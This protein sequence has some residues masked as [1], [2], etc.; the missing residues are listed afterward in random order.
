MG[1]RKQDPYQFYYLDKVEKGLCYW[2]MD[3]RTIDFCNSFM[4]VS[5]YL[6]LFFNVKIIMKFIVIISY[7]V[8]IFLKICWV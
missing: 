1:K 4:K 3:C 8:I 6:I 5:S 7:I 2:N